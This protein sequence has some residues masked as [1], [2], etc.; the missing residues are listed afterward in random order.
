MK[1][2]YWLFAFL[3]VLTLLR[4]IY[5]G[6]LELLPD[7]SYY[8]LWAQHP[9]L[10][11]YSKGPGVAFTILASTSLF[12]ASEF[13]VR[14]FSPLL[15]LGTT[16]LMF[17]FS[18]ALFRE[19]VAIWTAIAMNMLPIFNAGGTLMTIDPLS[20]FFWTAAMYTCWLA[21]AGGGRLNIYW[22]LTG[23]LIGIGFLCKYT[24]AMQAL[25]ILLFLALTPRYR[26]EFA[27]PGLYVMLFLFILCAAPV[28]VW[29]SHYDWITFR[30]LRNRGSLDTG[31]SLHI[32]EP[33]VFLGLHMGVYSPLMFLG[34]MAA[35]WWSLEKADVQFKTRYLLFFSVPLLLMYGLLSLKK[36]GEPNWTAPA[37]ISLGTLATSIW[38]EKARTTKWASAFCCSALCLGL[39]MSLVALN[40]DVLRKAGIPLP[41]SKD[42]SAKAR[43]GETSASCVD[44]VRHRLEQEGGKPLFLIG[45][46][47][48]IAASLSYYLPRGPVEGPGHPPVYIPESQ[49]FENQFS[50]WP[51][52]DQFVAM[53]P[54]FK[55]Q[56]EYYTE[57]QGMNPFVGRDALFVSDETKDH[58][59]SAI[60]SG[61][62]KVELIGLYEIRRRGL[63]LRN[64]SVF[65]CHHYKTLSL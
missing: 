36:A 27:R 13:G 56:D 57:E 22:P 55:S 19:S 33:F 51:R 61:F 18:R 20:I 23:V 65:A 4:L 30:H 35:L 50:F 47:Y 29:N 34:M 9:A 46:K 45:S 49:D 60:R 2:R 7:E 11:Y 53:P 44:A 59:D 24:N 16:L 17:W 32:G 10:S 31:F 5:I 48:Q 28:F 12:G 8:Y 38:V 62:E 14:F 6:Q 43:G 3:G 64:V 15:A 39:L 58:V 63:F 21:L 37:F 1:P 40:P 25:S 26:R 41:Y 42:P 54:G 52:Y